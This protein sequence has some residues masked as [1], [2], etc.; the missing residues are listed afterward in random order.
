MQC[1]DGRIGV[2]RAYPR[3]A[4]TCEEE[5]PPHERNAGEGHPCDPGTR[6]VM[7]RLP[8]QREDQVFEGTFEVPTLDVAPP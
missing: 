2:Y 1:R 3:R 6:P 7:W 8:V 4:G 5:R